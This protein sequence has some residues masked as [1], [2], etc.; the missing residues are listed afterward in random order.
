MSKSGTVRVRF[1]Q[2]C[3][4]AARSPPGAPT[5]MGTQQSPAHPRAAGPAGMHHLTSRR[6]AQCREIETPSTSHLPTLLIKKQGNV[7]ISCSINTA[8]SSPLLNTHPAQQSFICEYEALT[9]MHPS[10]ANSAFLSNLGKA[11]D[12]LAYFI[13]M[14][15]Q[16]LPSN[17]P[18]FPWALLSSWGRG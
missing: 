2:R 6:A 14:L 8:T 10:W 3:R 12:N 11:E 4:Q 5:P 17:D 13:L 7:L 16:A 18:L 15:P 1:L 9:L